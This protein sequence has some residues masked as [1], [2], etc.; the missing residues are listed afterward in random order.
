MA[1]LGDITVKLDPEIQEVLGR[2]TLN[3]VEW[4]EAY[5]MMR[6]ARDAAVA[7]LDVRAQEHEKIDGLW[8]NATRVNNVII[9]KMETYR[10]CVDGLFYQ[11]CTEHDECDTLRDILAT[12]RDAVDALDA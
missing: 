8:K 7:E 2:S 4:L 9:E 6:D 1:K 11:Y 5:R 12:C 3:A 10:M